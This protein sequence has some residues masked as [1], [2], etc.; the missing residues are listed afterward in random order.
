MPTTSNRDGASRSGPLT[1]DLRAE[2]LAR[3]RH[4][5]GRIHATIERHQDPEQFT[6]HPGVANV[7]EDAAQDLRAFEL[8]QLPNPIDASRLHV[9]EG[10]PLV[11]LHRPPNSPLLGPLL[12]AP[13][14]AVVLALDEWVRWLDRPAASEAPATHQAPPSFGKKAIA[15]L[16]LL[17]GD[18]AFDAKHACNLTKRSPTAVREWQ[19]LAPGTCERYAKDGSKELRDL[20]LVDGNPNVGTWLTDAGRSEADRRFGHRTNK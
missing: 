5:R 19:G 1:D 12:A 2:L 8:A 3:V 10:A 9:V 16:K 13:G 15:V 11:E 17:Y 7:V 14:D 20:G 6:T 4:W 18:K